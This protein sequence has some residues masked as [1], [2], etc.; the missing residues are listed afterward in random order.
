[1]G[2]IEQIKKKIMALFKITPATPQSIY[3]QEQ[4]SLENYFL[5]Q[6]IIYRGNAYELQQM[7]SQVPSNNSFWGNVSNK[8]RKIHIPIPSSVIDFYTNTITADLNSITV[9]EAQDIY[10]EIAKDNNINKIVET[11]LK[12]VLIVGDGA[13]K[14]SYDTSI[15]KYPIA[16]FISGDYVDYKY[17]RGRLEEVIFFTDVK[18]NKKTY[19]LAEIYGYGYINYELFDEYGNRL[20]LDITDYTSNLKPVT[21]DKAVILAIPFKVFESAMYRYRGKGLFA[22]KVEIVDSID[23]ITSEWLS[24]VRKGRVTKYIPESLIPR[25]PETGALDTYNFDFHTDFVK[26]AGSFEEGKDQIQVVQPDI[27]YQAFITSY[28]NYLD[29]LL[30]GIISPSTLGINVSAVATAASQREKEKITIQTRTKITAELTSVLK[31]LI[32]T[33][34]NTYNIAQNKKVQE[35]NVSVKFGEYAN[36]DFGTVVETVSKAK[37]SGIMSIEQCVEELYGDT[38]SDEEKQQEIERIKAEQ[39]YEE[40]D[41]S[42]VGDSEETIEEEETTTPS[43]E[44][45]TN[46]LNQAKQQLDSY[47]LP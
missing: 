4:L 15:S 27:N 17:N 24:A 31:A 25:N 20:S 8:D 10:D 26:V 28:E 13:F 1:M 14:I 11:A 37:M 16:E 36:T 21:F 33:L 38:L 12:N 7:F 47:K 40:L 39:G 46:A 2:F 29:L 6:R 19:R 34:L 35:Y 41:P 43:I 45:I 5:L 23:E 22:D 18:E 32:E 44:D 30:Q 3:I 9:D 42:L